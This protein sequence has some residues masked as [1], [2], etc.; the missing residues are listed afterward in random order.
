L[1]LSNIE[2]VIPRKHEKNEGEKHAM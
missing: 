2:I 1:A